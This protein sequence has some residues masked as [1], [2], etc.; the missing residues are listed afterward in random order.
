MNSQA[1][2]TSGTSVTAMVLGIVG[3]VFIWAPF[4]GFVSALLGIIFGGIGMS[5]TKKNPTLTGRGM[6]VA[7]LVC[8][9]IAVAVWVILIAAIGVLGVFSTSTSF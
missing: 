3:L 1:K 9:I 7:G 8:G 6:A 4:F 2:R 5:Q